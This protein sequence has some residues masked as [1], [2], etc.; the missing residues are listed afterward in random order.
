MGG[1]HSM[2]ILYEAAHIDT[3]R[4]PSLLAR[5][6][7]PTE[8][9]KKVQPGLVNFV[10]APCQTLI[11]LGDGVGGAVTTI[12]ISGEVNERAKSAQTLMSA[13]P[14]MAQLHGVTGIHVGQYVASDIS[15]TAEAKL[16]A[17]TLDSISFVVL[18]EA[19]GVPELEGV[20]SEL[21]DIAT[22]A[23]PGTCQADVYRLAY[24]M[25][26]R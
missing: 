5:L 18:I 26:A 1:N 20:T 25:N 23:C 6:N 17:N 8:W 12:R 4:S 14:A 10:R 3:F 15:G 24:M 9:S 22:K 7:H 16:R 11:S 2:F 19:I 21:L 13:V